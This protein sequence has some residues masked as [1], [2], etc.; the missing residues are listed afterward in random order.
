MKTLLRSLIG[1]GIGA[2]ASLITTSALAFPF[3]GGDR[4]RDPHP[5][6]SAVPEIN[7]NGA[8]AGA[9]LVLG[10]AAVILSRRKLRA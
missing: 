2:A 4:D 3:F 6:P 8:V 5:S 10:G 1:T 9:A 7:G